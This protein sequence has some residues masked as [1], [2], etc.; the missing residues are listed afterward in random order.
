MT[1]PAAMSAFQQGNGLRP[2]PGAGMDARAFRLADDATSWWRR[3]PAR[4]RAARRSKPWWRSG[5]S[6]GATTSRCSSQLPRS[7]RTTCRRLDQERAARHRGHRLRLLLGRA[8][9][10]CRRQAENRRCTLETQLCFGRVESRPSLHLMGVPASPG[11]R[12]IMEFSAMLRKEQND[13]LTQTGPGTPMG[14]HVPQ[15]LDAGA[16]GRRTA[17]ERMPAGAG[18]DALGAA[19]RLPR[20][21]R[22]ATA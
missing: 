12:I 20:H 13:L 21:A 8:G 5:P 15:L 2:R 6:R 17:G 3:C 11:H 18:E 19:A 14:Q 9:C 4:C 16:A 7:S 22:A 1:G 10:A